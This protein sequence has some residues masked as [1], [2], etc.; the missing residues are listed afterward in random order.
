MAIKALLEKT[1]INKAIFYTSAARLVQGC[2]GLLVVIL[3]AKKLTSIEQ[4][5]YFTFTSILAIQLFFE[6]G[7]NNILN[8]YVAHEIV[9]AEFVNGQLVG[10]EA[11][12]SRISSLLHFSVKI[13]AILSV[14]LL[15]LL[16]LSGIVFFTYFSSQKGVE[17]KYPWI[18]LSLT[19]SL[20]FLISPLIAFL[21]GLGKVKEMALMQFLQQCAAIIG[22]VGSLL[23]GAKLYAGGIALLFNLCVCIL[24]IC[25]KFHKKIISIYKIP[26]VSFV[27]YKKEIFPYQW[28]IAL[29]WISSY[30]IFQLF[31]PVL[32]AIEGA[33]VAGQMGMTLSVLN[34]ILSLSDSWVTTKIPLFSG[35]I[36]NRNYLKLDQLFNLT[37]RQAFFV[38]LSVLFFFLCFLYTIDMLHFSVSGK[39]LIDRF[40]PYMLVLMLMFTI[41]LRQLYGGWA[42]YLRCHKREPLLKQSMIMAFLCTVST[43]GLGHVYGVTGIV[44]GYTFLSIVSTIWIYIIYTN[45]RKKWHY[46][47]R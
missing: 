13:Y 22:L 10:D 42:I 47:I 46:A 24:F 45:K 23:T 41:V 17:W 15:L 35:L 20:Y 25:I 37:L 8:Q 7:L 39:L 34:A 9:H 12:V 43:F 32:F 19:T 16:L 26:I 28:K 3:V 33:A 30:F 6:L 29:S 1:G 11:A 2:G 44:C 38:N 4:G 27:S 18:L 21:Q 5:Y 31:N 36:A 40:L 14:G